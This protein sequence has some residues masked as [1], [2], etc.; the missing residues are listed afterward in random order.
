[1]ASLLIVRGPGIGTQIVIRE[2]SQKIGRDAA[3]EIHF[4]DSETSRLHAEIHLVEGNAIL[5]DLGSSNGTIVNGAKIHER[6]A[7]PAL[8][9]P[10]T[11][12]LSSSRTSSES[13][14]VPR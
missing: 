7:A 6:V 10:S 5:K 11:P 12:P 9:P 13:M 1:M 8:V 4:D 3:C 2:T 14:G